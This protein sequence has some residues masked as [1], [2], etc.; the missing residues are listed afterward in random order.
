TLGDKK[1]KKTRIIYTETGKIQGYIEDGAHVF[2]GIP[3]AEPPVG[4]LRLN[5]PE[6]KKSWNDVLVAL[7]YMPVAPQ[8]P[9]NFPPSHQ[10]EADCL[11]LN[12]WTPGCDNKKRPVLFWIHGGSHIMGS[13]RLL[14]G[15]DLSRKGDIVLVSI[16]YRL[17]P[18]G[19]L[20][21]PGAPPNVGQL[22]QIM[23]LTWVHDNI[24]LFG[25][26]SKNITIF[27]QS[28]GATSVC[29]LMATPKAT[30]LFNR[31]ISQSGAVQPQGFEISTR[32]TTAE[33]ILKELNLNHDDLQKC[34]LSYY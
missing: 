13:G 30:G 12:I 22:D 32:K 21:I 27:G 3:Y 18:L 8:P 7:E 33:M 1:L 15:R 4:E 29:A 26:D 6:S 20:Y 19:Y 24:E 23:A 10:N 28:A 17:G 14:N 31:V 9:D 25:G 34:N 16:N 11:N 5:A 2:K